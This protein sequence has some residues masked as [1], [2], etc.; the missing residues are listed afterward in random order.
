MRCQDLAQYAV[1]VT[2]ARAQPDKLS[3][4]YMQIGLV[5]QFTM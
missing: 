1:C 4:G 2:S 5:F 3:G